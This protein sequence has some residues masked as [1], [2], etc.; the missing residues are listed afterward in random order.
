MTI[1]NSV[2]NVIFRRNG[3]VDAASM[4]ADVDG[5]AGIAAPC[6][7]RSTMSPL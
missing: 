2:M 5:L 4:P 3:G 6:V 7:T 1:S